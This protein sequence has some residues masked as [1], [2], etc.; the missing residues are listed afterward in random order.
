MDPPS[1]RFFKDILMKPPAPLSAYRA[2]TNLEYS[3]FE[4]SF[5]LRALTSSCVEGT[6]LISMTTLDPITLIERFTGLTSRPSSW[7]FLRSESALDDAF[8]SIDDGMTIVFPLD[9]LRD[10]AVTTNSWSLLVGERYM[11]PKSIFFFTPSRVIS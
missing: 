1:S 10:S 5:G 11:Y 3:T 7:S 8:I 6:P 2:G 4:I 9:S